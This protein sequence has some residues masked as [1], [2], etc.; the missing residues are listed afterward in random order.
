MEEKKPFYDE[1]IEA[2]N[3][4]FYP[5]T[6][7]LKNKLG[8]MDQSELD[9]KER[10][11]VDK[12][13]SELHDKPIV[14][15]FDLKHLCAIHKYLFDDIYDWAGEFRTV[16]MT[17]D[18]KHSYF[19]SVTNIAHT[20]EDDLILLNSNYRSVSS[21]DQFIDFITDF[22]VSL[23]NIHPF[24]EGNG[25][26]IREFLREFVVKKSEYHGLEPVD[27]DWSRANH[28][29]IEEAMPMARMYKYSIRKE[30]EKTIVPLE[31]DNQMRL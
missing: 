12:K 2:W 10:E 20:L 29:V 1:S 23:L 19:A 11:I 30:I 5:G 14:G 31:R 18:K 13:L 22:Y 16:Y 27:L 3:S 4:Y 26:A 7:V 8:I 24:R 25:R 15:S 6:D 28:T 9:K 17:R 21:Y